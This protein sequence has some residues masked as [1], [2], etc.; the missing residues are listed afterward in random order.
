V[1]PSDAESVALRARVDH[2]LARGPTKANGAT[3]QGDVTRLAQACAETPRGLIMVGPHLPAE[4][5]LALLRLAEITGFP[6]LCEATSQ[7]RWL[8]NSAPKACLIDGFDW[9]LRSQ[10]LREALRPDLI[11]SFGGTPTSGAYERLLNDGFNGRRFVVSAH[12]FPDPHGLANELVSSGSAD[13]AE[14]TLAWLEAAELCD[15]SARAAF[16]RAWSDAND[17]AWRVMERE[18]GRTTAVLSEPRA[19]RAVLEPLP[20]GCWLVLGNSLPIREVDAYVARGTRRVRVLSQRGANGIDGLISGAAGA[21]STTDEPTLLLLGDVSFSHDLGGLAAARACRGAF[22]IVVIDNGGGRIFEQLPVFRQFEGRP[23][24][25][26]FWLTPQGLELAHAAQLF[27]YRYARL[28]N[29][30]EVTTGVRQAI[31][32][33]G[34]SILHVIV[35]GS[36]ARETEQRVRS[37]LERAAELEA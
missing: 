4:A 30:F 22:V 33:H 36:S 26:R 25:E 2:L 37:E 21:A 15:T 20:E 6:L 18:I 31:A 12:G 35:E 32:T 11:L 10:R 28:S 8:A 27:G 34:V 29:V 1:T 7:L 23:D 9:L 5:P 16:A 17:L 14:A 24:A 13:A 3:L 19:I